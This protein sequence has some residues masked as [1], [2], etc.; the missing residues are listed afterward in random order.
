MA[1]PKGSGKYKEEYNKLAYNYCLLG[2]TDAD[3]GKYFEVTET[4]INNW[5]R[6]YPSFFVSIK[7]GK[8]E[9]DANVA[10]ALYHRATGY[11]HAEDKIFQYEGEPVIVPTVKHYPPDTGAA[12][13]WLKNRQPEKWRDKQEIQ[14]DG[15]LGIT[16]KWD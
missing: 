11:S 13:A 15:D 16:I 6:D 3:L 8:E 7:E 2:A 4:T 10:K 9:A 1:R 14:H 5:K 12:M